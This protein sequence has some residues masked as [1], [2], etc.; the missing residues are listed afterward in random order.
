MDLGDLLF[1]CILLLR[2][3]ISDSYID[4]S[5]TLEMT[6]GESLCFL[7]LVSYLWNVGFLFVRLFSYFYNNSPIVISTGG[8]FC[9]RS[10][11][12]FLKAMG[13]LVF[14]YFF[15]NGF[16]FFMATFMDI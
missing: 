9:F 3:G 13:F 7:G 4:L 12:I 16:I 6:I 8:G 11:E 10:G 2:F 5:A 14:I 1:L 15:I